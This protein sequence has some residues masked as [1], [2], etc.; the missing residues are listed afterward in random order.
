MKCVFNIIVFAIG[1][2]FSS[3]SFSSSQY[4]IE[5]LL[6][7]HGSSFQD[8]ERLLI[9]QIEPF[10]IE[11]TAIEPNTTNQEY[12]YLVRRGGVSYHLKIPPVKHLKLKVYRPISQKY[13]TKESLQFPRLLSLMTGSVCA[14]SFAS[15]V[16][17]CFITPKDLSEYFYSATLATLFLWPT[18]FFVFADRIW[19]NIEFLKLPKRDRSKVQWLLQDEEL[20]RLI[21]IYGEEI[22]HELD[23][24]NRHWED[25]ELLKIGVPYSDQKHYLECPI[26]LDSVK[27]NGWK[28]GCGHVFCIPCI[29]AWYSKSDTCPVCMQIMEN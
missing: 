3:N 9:T 29:E 19:S 7:L 2:I 28:I 5:V 6:G 22:P 1:I 23:V 17:N 8:R 15:F 25:S 16:K 14:V 18:V 21:T 10:E 11:N 13:S 20:N 26:C 24:E 27:S 4:E 12:S